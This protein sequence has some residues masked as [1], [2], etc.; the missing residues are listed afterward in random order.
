MRSYFP[1]TH[2]RALELLEQGRSPLIVGAPGAGKSTLFDAI[3]AAGT[4]PLVLRGSAGA[5]EPF[6]SLRL[7]GWAHGAQAGTATSAAVEFLTDAI[8]DRGLA[9]D[10]LDLLDPSTRAAVDHVMR[11]SRKPILATS[12]H[13]SHR[14]DGGPMPLLPFGVTLQLGA[15]STGDFAEYMNEFLPGIANTSTLALL[16]SASGGIP[17]LA[18]EIVETTLAHD[19]LI[20]LNGNWFLTEDL[21]NDELTMSMLEFLQP[22]TSDQIA[23]LGRLAERG[24]ID[25]EL[26]TELGSRADLDHLLDA[27]LLAIS[28][29][30]ERSLVSIRPGLVGDYLLHTNGSSVEAEGLHSSVYMDEVF[31]LRRLTPSQ[32]DTIH[33]RNQRALSLSQKAWR[34]SPTARTAVPLLNQLLVA[35]RAPSNLL[36]VLGH[37]VPDQCEPKDEVALLTWE[38]QWHA[39]HG[40]DMPAAR[41]M[42]WDGIAKYP[43][44]LQE[45]VRVYM[46]LQSCSSLPPED[47]SL[48]QALALQSK[49]QP[50]ATLSTIPPPP[51]KQD[52]LTPGWAALAAGRANEA[53]EKFAEARAELGEDIKI[54]PLEWLT[55]FGEEFAM[56]AANQIPGAIRVAAQRRDEAISELSIIKLRAQT[57]VLVTVLYVQGRD[58]IAQEMLDDL[59][60]TNNATIDEVPFQTAELAFMAV[61]HARR[62]HFERAEIYQQQAER[63]G[64]DNPPTPL[65]SPVWSRAVIDSMTGESDGMA[66]LWSEGEKF[67]QQGLYVSAM[68]TWLTVTKAWSPRQLERIK[69]VASLTQLEVF[70]EFIAYHEAL[71][72]QDASALLEC[73]DRLENVSYLLHAAAASAHAAKLLAAQGDPTGAASA[74]AT[75]ARLASS[76]GFSLVDVLAGRS[77]EDAL[78][79]REREITAMVA[80]GDSNAQ[81]AETLGLSVRTVETHVRRVLHKLGVANRHELRKTWNRGDG[82]GE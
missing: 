74:D 8:I 38:A 3:I 18:R 13:T 70:T 33:R 31:T 57:L 21:W 79:P 40:H 64:V 63:L 47:I 34:E 50:A 72:A 20:Q 75:A 2:T 44:E 43:S 28:V 80:Q 32:I 55:D 5:I 23:L 51:S 42:L 22:T 14:R 65:G 25:F 77:V 9:I 60:L 26:A 19:G 41:A 56:L 49:I 24:P 62:G 16:Y 17:G 7:S 82:S 54:P 35:G 12:R 11:T 36:E 15:L 78:T 68:M 37:T 39:W 53:L 61:V 76:I 46:T 69:E 59:L 45:L 48:E 66:A 52:L 6:D 81:V 67:A 30:T 1:S 58:E 29:E 4:P 27:G 71:S 10:D 73:S